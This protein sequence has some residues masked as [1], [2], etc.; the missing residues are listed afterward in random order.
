MESKII[1]IGFLDSEIS[2]SFSRSS[3]PGGQNVNKVNTQAELRFDV[4]S[5]GLLTEEQ[6]VIL[7]NKLKKRINKNNELIIVVQS[8]RSQIAN[9]EKAILKFYDEISKALK[10]VKPR[11]ATKPNLESIERRLKEKKENSERKNRRN[12]NE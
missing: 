10:P 8:E 7:I 2:F 6:K 5:S 4:K 3:G 1:N 12:F 11:K 9:K